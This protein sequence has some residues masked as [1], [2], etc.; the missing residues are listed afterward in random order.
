VIFLYVAVVVV[1]GALPVGFLL[2]RLYERERAEL[3]RPPAAHEA[4]ARVYRMPNPREILAELRGPLPSRPDPSLTE[5]V[6]K[7]PA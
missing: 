7:G 5:R 6:G 1:A 2:G 3:R 4:L